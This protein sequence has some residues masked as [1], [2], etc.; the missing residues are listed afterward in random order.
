[1]WTIQCRDRLFPSSFCFLCKDS[2]IFHADAAVYSDQTSAPLSSPAQVV[3]SPSPSH[4]T[5]T[6]ACWLPLGV[7]HLA[8]EEVEDGA[9]FSFQASVQ[10]A[11][12]G[13]RKQI[14]ACVMGIFSERVLEDRGV[15]VPLLLLSATLPKKRPERSL[16]GNYQ[17]GASIC[18]WLNRQKLFMSAPR[19]LR[20]S[21]YS[22]ETSHTHT[23]TQKVLQELSVLN[24]LAVSSPRARPGSG[25]ALIHIYSFTSL[26]SFPLY[27][28]R[29]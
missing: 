20:L 2:E 24:P 12:V 5:Q 3:K 22:T 29:N 16:I 28:Q 7:L 4:W 26:V 27:S 17:R 10:S 19:A 25:T 14:G 9:D 15:L 21:D 18:K 1:M 8:E 11:R 6:T 23:H 13:R